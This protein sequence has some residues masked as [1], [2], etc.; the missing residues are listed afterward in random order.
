MPSGKARIFYIRVHWAI[1]YLKH[2]LLLKGTKRGFF[3]IT[4]RGIEVLRHK[5]RPLDNDFLRQFP[6]FIGFIGIRKK[7]KVVL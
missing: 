6:E 3:K 4:G 1:S 7:D 5:E 2:S